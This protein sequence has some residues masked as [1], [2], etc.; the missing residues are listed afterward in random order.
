MIGKVK[1]IE[2]R[3]H[4]GNFTLNKEYEVVEK[5]NGGFNITCDFIYLELDEEPTTDIF[6]FATCKFEF[7]DKEIKLPKYVVQALCNCADYANKS[8]QQMDIFMK[9]VRKNVDEDFNF[10]FLSACDYNS[11]EL[12]K[13]DDANEMLSEIEYGMIP[14]EESIKTIEHVL[15]MWIQ[16]YKESE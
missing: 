1:C 14:D 12:D 4:N 9:W 16:K 6:E 7:L 5:K 13:S 10:G 15:N 3:R 8:S 2:N 11:Y